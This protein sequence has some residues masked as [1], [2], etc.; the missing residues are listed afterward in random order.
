MAFETPDLLDLAYLAL[1]GYQPTPSV[2]RGNLVFFQVD[3]DPDEAERL[4]RSPER[5][6]TGQFHQAWLRLRRAVD[7]FEGR[8]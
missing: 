5:Q 8:R 2:R 6:F 3:I 1:K 4:L 7:N